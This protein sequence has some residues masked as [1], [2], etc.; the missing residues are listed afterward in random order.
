MALA[1]IKRK[2]KRVELIEYVSDPDEYE[3]EQCELTILEPTAVSKLPLFFLK[4]SLAK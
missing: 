1:Q 2:Q 4:R 3:G